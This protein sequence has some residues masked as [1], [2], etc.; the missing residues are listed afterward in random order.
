MSESRAKTR[1]DLVDEKAAAMRCANICYNINK[2]ARPYTDYPDQVALYCK[3]GI[4]MGDTNHSKRF[5]GNFINSVGQSVSNKIKTVL[6]QT[7]T[8]TGE[9]RPVKIIA[10]KDTLKHRTRQLVCLVTV[11]PHSECLIQHVYI[12]HNIIRHHSTEDVA[13]HIF[14]SVKD[15]IS[16]SQYEGGSYDGAYHHA[17]DSVP[18]KLDKLFNVPSEGDGAGHSDHDYLHRAGLLEEK[19]KKN[20]HN[21][22]VINLCETLSTLY[23]DHSYG[24][25]HEE[26]IEISIA[27]DVNFTQLQ[28]FSKTRFA[29]HAKK[30]FYSSYNDIPLIIKHYENI[31]NDGENVT[32]SKEKRDKADHAQLMLNKIKNKAFILKLAGLVDIYNN[33]SVIVSQL[34]IVNVLPFERLDNF[35][36]KHEHM[37]KMIDT[38][39]DHTKCDNKCLWPVMHKDKDAIIK[40]KFLYLFTRII[41]NI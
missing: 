15:F 37:K 25:N 36:E 11:F 30:V 4:W 35:R 8:Q 12:S 19:A 32:S 29:N 2:N 27:L 14:D 39:H 5:S 3:A 21:K 41:I 1:P 34:Q 17:I 10:D 31:K 40:G 7:L 28:K 33:F 16:P 6:K 13:N 18:K 38:I 26:L 22:W 9:L 20:D 23:N 24:K